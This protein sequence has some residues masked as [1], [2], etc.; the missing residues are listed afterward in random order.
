MFNFICK[1]IYQT[2]KRYLKSHKRELYCLSNVVWTFWVKFFSIMVLKYI[3]NSVLDSSWLFLFYFIFCAFD[4]SW[5]SFFL[6]LFSSI[7]FW[8]FCIIFIFFIFIYL[9]LYSFDFSWLKMRV[10]PIILS[11]YSVLIKSGL[12]SFG[13][14]DVVRS[15]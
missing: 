4:F 14:T 7:F 12:L 15:N 13:N 2:I 10:F 1:N 3:K 6:F 11:L 9:F 5:F 8:F